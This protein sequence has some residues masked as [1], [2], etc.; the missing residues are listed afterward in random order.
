MYLVCWVFKLTS[1]LTLSQILF[2]TDAIG[3]YDFS[4]GT[5]MQATTSG[6]FTAFKSDGASGDVPNP[7]GPMDLSTFQENRAVRVLL[8]DASTESYSGAAIETA[9]SGRHSRHAP[10]SAKYACTIFG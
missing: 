9:A 2:E 7:D 1:S 5:Q 8:S 4:S 6:D 10:S 3:T